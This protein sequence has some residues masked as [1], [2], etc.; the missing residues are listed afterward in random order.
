MKFTS[1]SL[2]IAVFV[3]TAGSSASPAD[4]S[5]VDC[6]RAIAKA[7]A[8]FVQ[9]KAKALSKCEATIVA[10]GSGGP[11][12]DSTAAA[13]I[14]KATTKLATA[15]GKSCGGDDRICGGD[16]TNEDLPATLGWPTACPNFE[17]G[18]CDGLIQDCGD[19]ADCLVCLGNRAVD[20]AIAL[21]YDDLL[22]PS[23]GALEKCQASIGKA[24]SMFLRSKS[25]ALQKCWD[26]QL[27]GKLA[28]GATCI[29]P[30]P[31]DG[32]YLAA[33]QKAEDKKKT[34]ICKACGGTDQTCDGTGDISPATIGFPTACPAVTI[35]GGA[36]CGGTITDLTSLVACVDCVTEFKVDCIDRAQVP[37]AAVYPSECNVCVAPPPSGPCPTAVEYTVDGTRYD[38]DLGFTG[39]AHDIEEPSNARL[40]LAVSGCAGA[41]Q[42]T[43]GQCTVSG[44]VPNAG[45]ATFDNHRCQDQP[46]VA[47]GTDVDCTNAGAAGPCTYFFGPP[48]GFSLG[49]IPTCLMNRIASPVAGTVDFDDGGA[50]ISL[51]VAVAVHFTS[52]LAQPCPSC[53]RAC[54]NDLAAGCTV[55]GDCPGGT[56]GASPL[57]SLSLIH[58]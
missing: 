34:T 56:C 38:L 36:A 39:L 46:W 44:P 43:C 53:R 25:K 19:I 4:A 10:H 17:R 52:P 50:S 21:Y 49:G 9:A 22:L 7:S 58:I 35:P 12:P 33:I 20:Q 2:A 24:T 26:A 13:T 57:C 27:K 11:C 6:Q 42:P 40:T 32:K 51:P 16:T 14:S 30:D 8:Q 31:G 41:S 54:S 47:C 5:T 48:Q 1:L 28:P 45:G 23:S 55:D 37:E 18:A 29:A 3:L 15:I